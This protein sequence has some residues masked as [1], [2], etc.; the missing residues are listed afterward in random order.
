MKEF[1]NSLEMF[2]YHAGSTPI[3]QETHKDFLYLLEVQKY[4]ICL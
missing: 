4:K 2:M 3:T 1:L